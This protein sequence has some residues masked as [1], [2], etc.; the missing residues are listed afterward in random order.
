MSQDKSKKNTL[1]KCP[2]E[3][4]KYENE[5]MKKIT[6]EFTDEIKKSVN[7]NKNSIIFDFGAGTGLIGLNLINEVNHVILKIFHQQ[8]LII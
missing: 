6:K 8:C 2:I 7:L 1:H 4:E 5:Q 3:G